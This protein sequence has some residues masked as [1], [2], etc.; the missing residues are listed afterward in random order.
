MVSILVRYGLDMAVLAFFGLD[1]AVLAFF[2]AFLL[3]ATCFLPAFN[4][5]MANL[6]LLTPTLT[7]NSHQFPN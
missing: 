7:I 6:F 3:P 2:L 1:M 4:K 5:H